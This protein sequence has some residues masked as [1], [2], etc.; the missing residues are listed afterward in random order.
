MQ[1]SINIFYSLFSKL[2]HFCQ[3]TI[4]TLAYCAPEVI[5]PLAFGGWDYRADIFGLGVIVFI[6]SVSS[7]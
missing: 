3:E 7:T 4:G 2:I 6:M 1:P 5:A